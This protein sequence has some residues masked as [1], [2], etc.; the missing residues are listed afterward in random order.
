MRFIYEAQ[1]ASALDHP[2]ICTIYEI[3]ETTEGQAEDEQIFIAMAYYEGETLAEK[4]KQQKAN[5]KEILD[6]AIG[7]ASGLAAA[8]AHGI[9]HPW[10]AAL[11]PLAPRRA[12]GQAR[13][14]AGERDDHQRRHGED[15]RFRAGEIGRRNAA[16]QNRRDHGHG[17]LPVAGTGAAHRRRS[18]H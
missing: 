12:P 3:G 9:I 15:S 6:W 2:N 1:A 11:A 5:S 13:H 16:H 8:H 7:I 4:I 17:G 14:Q 18:S 10:P